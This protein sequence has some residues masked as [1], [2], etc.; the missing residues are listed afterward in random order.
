MSDRLA[1]S[2]RDISQYHISLDDSHTVLTQACLGV[3]L[4]DP[5]VTNGADSG[6]L[7]QYAAEHWVTHARVKNVASRVRD[8]ME[9]LFNPDQP[10]FEVWVQLHDVDFLY[11]GT[12]SDQEP[13]AKPLFYA[14]LCGFHE[15]VEHLTFKYPQ[16]TST[17]GGRRG[18]ALHSASSAGHLQI[19]RTLLRHGVGVDVRGIENRTP[20]DFASCS[21]CRDVVQ[22]LLDH[23]ADV[24]SQDDKYNI[25]LH[26]A[27]GN[28]HVDVVQVLL[29]HNADVSSKDI[30]GYTPLHDAVWCSDRNSE[31]GYPQIV[32][33]LLEHGA[34]TNARDWTSDTATYCFSHLQSTHLQSTEP[35]HRTHSVGAWR[36]RR[37]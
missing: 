5:D 3:L 13:R 21:G 10:Y 36:G 6:P 29:E 14:A 20:L 19:V 17:R 18:T 11:R 31:G 16:S 35:R 25:P 24:N 26:G 7:A 37:C 23:G 15:L 8:G 1:T 2:T 22:C 4:R 32:R 30:Y 27:A 12:E 33:L 28:G 9:R 34:N